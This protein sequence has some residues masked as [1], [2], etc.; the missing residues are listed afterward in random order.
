MYVE[1]S[2]GTLTVEMQSVDPAMR[3]TLRFAARENPR[4]GFLFVST[5]IG[6]YMPAQPERL[7]QACTLLAEH[8]PVDLPGPVLCLGVAEA[9][10]ALALGVHRTYRARRGLDDVYVWHSSRLRLP[11]EPVARFVE[12]H[13]HAPAHA[14][15][16]TTE[17]PLWSALPEIKSVVIIDDEVTTGDT[18]MGVWRALAPLLPK[19]STVKALAL[20]DW[21]RQ[22]DGG[23]QVSTLAQGRF[24]FEPR[25]LAP[26]PQMPDVVGGRREVR[27]AMARHGGRL[28]MQH[29][30][31]PI[32][33]EALGLRVRSG[34]RVLVV[35]AGEHQGRAIRLAEAVDTAG[36]TGWFQFTTRAPVRLEGPIRSVFTTTDAYGE[37]IRDH[38]YNFEADRWDAVWVCHESNDAEAC[39]PLLDATGGRWV[40]EVS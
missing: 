34:E 31:A 22:R 1:L 32:D 3:D 35:G 33:L 29:V 9:G 2:T 17:S 6:R 23:V 26:E 20:S 14:L 21:S 39:R 28:G 4:R 10:V 36:G 18:L 30:A 19:C 13:S 40:P 37:G 11:I 24:D 5:V 27:C 38:L 8:L 15:Y 7:H 16:T 25:R 12:A